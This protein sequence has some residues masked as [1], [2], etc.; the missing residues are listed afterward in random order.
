M[1]KRAYEAPAI[2]ELLPSFWQT[3]IVD[4]RPWDFEGVR[5]AVI[6]ATTEGGNA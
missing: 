4:N 3:Y 5:Q 6:D 2:S 1:G